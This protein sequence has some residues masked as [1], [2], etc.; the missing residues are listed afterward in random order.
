M[1]TELTIHNGGLDLTTLGNV[2]AKSNYF[3]DTKDAAQA[4]VKV[5]AGQELGIG[6][7]AAMTGV[8]IVNG[9]VAIGANLMA[10]AVKRSGKYNYRVLEQT[11]K[12]CRIAFYE[13]KEVIGESVFTIEDAKKAG[14]KNLDKFPRN[15]LFARALSNGVR[16]YCP[17]VFD[18]TVYTPDELRGGFDSQAEEL[19]PAPRAD[20]VTG[21]VLEGS[22]IV[23]GARGEGAPPKPA[24][25]PAHPDR[26]LNEVKALV[27]DIRKAGGDPGTIT[28]RQMYDMPQ[29]EYEAYVSGMRKMRD[30]LI[31][32]ADAEVA[33]VAA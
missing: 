25:V 14:T 11:D 32:L 10:A 26:D 29:A 13:G 5:L 9:R 27:A 20:V 17:D 22:P 18:A 30:D 21:E 23:K 12:I 15:M 6:P 3:Q 24:Y 31:A 4:I 8:Y 28:A 33:E 19:P 16:W 1:S 7:I 2:L